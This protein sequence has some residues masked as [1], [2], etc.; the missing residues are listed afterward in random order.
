MW[1]KKVG[2]YWS[3]EGA[4]GDFISKSYY[5]YFHRPDEVNNNPVKEVEFTTGRW[6]YSVRPVVSLCA[7]DRILLKGLTSEQYYDFFSK[8]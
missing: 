5:L 2:Y 1:K 7:K 8:Y 3:G 6:M 4:Y